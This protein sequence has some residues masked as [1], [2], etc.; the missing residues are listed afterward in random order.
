MNDNLSQSRELIL[1]AREALRRND[2]N[3][4]RALG[5]EAAL[6]SPDFED[7]WLILVASDDN[8]ED[9]LAYARKAE[10]LNPRSRRNGRWSGLRES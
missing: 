5:E 9:A 4:A 10:E 7:A 3:A 8:P 6:L 1:Q 2:R